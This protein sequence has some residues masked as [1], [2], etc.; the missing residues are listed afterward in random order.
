MEGY[1]Q[2]KCPWC[3]VAFRF[4]CPARLKDAYCPDCGTKLVA[5]SYLFKGEWR[6]VVHCFGKSGSRKIHYKEVSKNETG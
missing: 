2:G 4:A 5:T 6:T 3:Q 1:T